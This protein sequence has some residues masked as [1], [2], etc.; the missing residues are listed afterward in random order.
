MI[1]TISPIDGSVYYSAKE[2][3]AGDIQNTLNLAKKAFPLWSDL[4]VSERSVFVTLFVKA[5]KSETDEIAEEITHQMGR[6]L[7]QS[8]GEISGF[9]ERASY[10]I[11]IAEESLKNYELKDKKNFK[12]WIQRVPLGVVAILSPWN[13][14]FLT[15]VNAIVPALLAGNVVVLKHSFQTPLVSERYAKAAKKAGF[16]KGVFQILHLNHK[17]AGDFISDP[18]VDGVMFTGS[19]RGGIAIQNSLRNKFIPCGLELGGKD[20]AYVRHDASLESTIENLVDGSFFNS[21]QSC[22]GIER[23]YVHQSLYKNFVDGFVDITKKYRLGNPMESKI[24][25]G[26][27]V[28]TSAANYVRNQIDTAVKAGANSLVDEGLFSVSKRDS[29]YLSPHVLVNVDHNMEVMRIE[30]FGPVVGIM[31]V[32]DDESAIKLMNDSEYG[33][34]ASIWTNDM[35]KAVLIGDRIETG[36]VYM[37][38]C[39]YLDPALAWTGVKNSGRGVTLSKIGFDHVTRVKSFHFRK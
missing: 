34:T 36:T 1:K 12:R 33:L 3:T 15:S 32:K 29:P 25:L 31:A 14:P 6:P 13:Y 30:S 7:S 9:V 35:D 37:N 20:P 23:I 10:M 38:R 22:C 2:H 17:N 18:K 16:P 26:P 39:D 5:I 4:S 8:P 11:D 28:K 24:N 19:V 27:M 21:G